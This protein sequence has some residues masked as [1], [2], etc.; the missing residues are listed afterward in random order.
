MI[1]GA[2]QAEVPERATLF[3]TVEQATKAADKVMPRTRLWKTEAVQVKGE[4]LV[5]VRHWP[6]GGSEISSDRRWLRIGYKR[7]KKV[8][9]GESE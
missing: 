4:T 7:K 6:R 5:V 3:E 2:N 9:N 1:F 8:T